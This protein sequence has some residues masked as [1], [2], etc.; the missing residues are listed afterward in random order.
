M[1]RASIVRP[2]QILD[3]LATATGDANQ[4]GFGLTR[5]ST[6]PFCRPSRAL[7]RAPIPTSLSAACK[8]SPCASG[9]VDSDIAIE[10][11]QCGVIGGNLSRL[12]EARKGI[13]MDELEAIA[14][15]RRRGSRS[16]GLIQ[17]G[18]ALSAV[19]SHKRLSAA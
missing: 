3:V 14:N 19:D 10:T 8:T 9:F 6:P 15:R 13:L 4:S 2:S 11:S 12:L 18:S 5:S 16:G 1:G 17:T 7:M